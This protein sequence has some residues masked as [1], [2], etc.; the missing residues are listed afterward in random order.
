MKRDGKEDS[1]CTPFDKL[2]T[3]TMCQYKIA[4]FQAST[5]LVETYISIDHQ[6]ALMSKFFSSYRSAGKVTDILHE[7]VYGLSSSDEEVSLTLAVNRELVL[8]K[9]ALQLIQTSVLLTQ[10]EK[11]DRQW[12][13]MT[14]DM[15]HVEGARDLSSSD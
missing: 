12:R 8:R 5:H 6:S 11:F 10:P 7:Q 4:S 13:L 1:R 9:T 3:R 14:Y 15:R 2:L